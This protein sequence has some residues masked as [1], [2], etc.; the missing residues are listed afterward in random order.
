MK[1]LP[2]SFWSLPPLAVKNFRALPCLEV[3]NDYFSSSWIC[4][5]T[6]CASLCS[7]SLDFCPLSLS[8]PLT[9]LPLSLALCGAE[10]YAGQGSLTE[11]HPSPYKHFFKPF[12]LRQG[13]PNLL[14]C[15]AWTWTCD[16]PTSALQSVRTAD[17]TTMG[18]TQAGDHGLMMY[19]RA[20]KLEFRSFMSRKVWL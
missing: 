5:G 2:G 8:L 18:S 15:R 10:D 12:I 13:L 14:S 17:F 9:F 16:P 3:D 6:L 7:H 20:G 4:L 11:L 1:C 19:M